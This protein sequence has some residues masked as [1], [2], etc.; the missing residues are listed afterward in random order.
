VKMFAIIAN[1]STVSVL[2]FF[3]QTTETRWRRMQVLS[4][5]KETPKFFWGRPDKYQLVYHAMSDYLDLDERADI[6]NRRFSALTDM[7][8]LLRDQQSS[9]HEEHLEWIVII[10]ICITTFLGLA[11]IAS[12]LFGVAVNESLTSFVTYFMDAE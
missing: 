6:L 3:R 5:H 2:A 11:Q 10:L 7:L 4:G 1:Y 12:L 8:D 9:K